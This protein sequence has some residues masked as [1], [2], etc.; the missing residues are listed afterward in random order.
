M[1]SKLFAVIVFVLTFFS[2]FVS[3]S[4]AGQ[5]IYSTFLGG[6]GIWDYG[7]GTAVDT[8]GNAYITGRTAS[9]DFPTTSGAFDTTI[10]F[11][12]A[13][14]TKLNVV[15]SA[16]VYSTYLG[17]SGADYGYG[18]T[19]D[20]A[21][22]AY[23]TGY[24]ESSDFPTTPG[25]FDTT[26]GPWWDVFVTKLNINGSV[27]IYSTFLGGSNNDFGYA[28]A[29]NP[30]G[31]AYITGW[32][33]STNFSTTPGAFDTTLNGSNDS[34]VI[35]LNAGGSALEYSTYLG[36]SWTD[37]G[38]GIAVDEIGNAYVTGVT[39]SSDFPTTMGV[40]DNTYN[41]STDIF[42]TKINSNGSALIYSTYL[43]GTASDCSND[44]VV[45]SSGN[46]F[47]TGY[48]NSF[49]FPITT[50]AYDTI[51]NAGS[52]A[53]VTKLNSMGSALIYSTFLGGNGSDIGSAIALDNIGN[54]YITGITDSS[55]FPTTF[56]TYDPS[57]NGYE[58]VFV[59]ALNSKGTTLFYSTFLGGDTTDCGY[60]ITVDVAGNVY[61][62]GYTG[63]ANFPI[64][65]GAFDS[66]Y[67]GGY[68]DGFV[69]K[70]YM[71]IVPL[72]ER[73]FYSDVNKNTSVD[74]GDLL[75]VQFGRR[76]RVNGATASNFYLPVTGDSLGLG[77]TISINSVNDTQVVITLGNSPI[78]TIPGIFS[79]STT[80]AGSPSGIDISATMTPDAIED[81]DG[82]D[83]VDGGILGIN[84]S[85]MDLLAT[86]LDQSTTINALTGGTAQVAPNGYYTEHQV[87]IPA[88]SLST[89]AT[90]TA[91]NPGQ[92]HGQLSAVSF[93]PPDL[94]F[95]SDT[96]ATLV[97]E[98]K[99][100]DAKL[101]AG[102]LENAMR[103]HQWKSQDS[104]WVLVPQT[105]SM[106]SVDTTNRTV[107][108]KIDKF[109]MVGAT[110]NFRL[111]NAD[112]GFAGN[113]TVVYANI[114]L[115][116][117]GATTTTVAPAPSGFSFQG[118]D[119]A[120]LRN[121]NPQFASGAELP[122][123][124]LLFSSTTSVTL[125]VTTA[126]IYTKH[127]LT[128]T[129]YTTAYSG[130]TVIL[131]QATLS[132]R[133]GWQNYAVLKIATQGTITTRAILTMEYKDH[134]DAN[135]QFKNDIIGGAEYQ[136]RV[137]LWREEYGFWQKIS[138]FQIV[139]RDENTVSVPITSL[140]ISQLYAVGVDTTAL[141]VAVDYPWEMYD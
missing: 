104:T 52:D 49:N 12:D 75:T 89:N 138:G 88:G 35:K 129:D 133:T 48:T 9:S 102:Y 29:L 114:A 141:P 44:I 28:I 25:A 112:F 67:N 95:S 94:T 139:N 77:A 66:T 84:D 78:L 109:N 68:Y 33:S 126:G 106:Q 18:I 20:S 91:G 100:A 118:C 27:L 4:I 96:P 90:I 79:M 21:G 74:Q 50:S 136:M 98:Y 82:I 62:T 92:N 26:I 41:G 55:D 127:K 80:T 45:D 117:V 58:D 34:F 111:R 65:A 56:G 5:L 1:K 39:N 15:G 59:T 42:V 51:H 38:S 37:G 23:I 137:Y 123:N 119:G 17:G 64:T 46:T 134:D 72:M 8:I 30:G 87:I 57:Y 19:V 105:Y 31:N 3:I 115:P 63:S 13:F 116:S 125:S 32:T 73:A 83:A 6:S 60:G 81:F 36:G 76:M 16:L 14:V 69:S 110:G 70:I 107:S 99:E 124:Q 24:T 140:S 54:A 7:Y 93:S 43:G 103:I 61:I 40:F 113:T 53:F 135:N 2:S 71:G 85:G 132:E 11:W 121:V 128:L 120:L 108:V 47:V 97:I 22:Y 131:T 101:E 10:N 86:V 122:Q 130:V